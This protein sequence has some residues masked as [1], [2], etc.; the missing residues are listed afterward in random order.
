MRMITQWVA[1]QI[2]TVYA[3]GVR[4]CR[5][6]EGHVIS[7]DSV[8]VPEGLSMY[9]TALRR[10]ANLLKSYSC[11]HRHMTSD[12]VITELL[13]KRGIEHAKDRPGKPNSTG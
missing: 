3:L 4:V 2:P 7:M 12:E 8:V 5:L 1:G 9:R 6:K 13:D 10:A 11:Y